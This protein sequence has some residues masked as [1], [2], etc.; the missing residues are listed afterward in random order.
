VTTAVRAAPSP[1]AR[2]LRSPLLVALWT[3]LGIEAIGG[4]VIFY[5][6][7][8]TGSTPGETL[9]VVTGVVLAIAYTIYQ[10]QHWSRVS[11]WRGRLDYT[12]GLIGACAMGLTLA[13]GLWLGLPWWRLRVA[14]H[15]AGPVAYPTPLSAAHNIMSMLVLTFVGAHL[16]AVLL[17]DRGARERAAV[18]ARHG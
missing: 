2:R 11:P 1:R 17:R 15:L 18:S 6:R 10:V 4:L 5:V 7:L 8:A 12:L 9:H 3:L 13:S 16:A 14:S